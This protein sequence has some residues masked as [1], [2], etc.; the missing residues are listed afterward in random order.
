M[1]KH[2]FANKALDMSKDKPFW[3]KYIEII[4]RQT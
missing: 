4:E 2:W 1:Q 3:Y